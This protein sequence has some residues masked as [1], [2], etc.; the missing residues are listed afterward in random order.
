MNNSTPPNSNFPPNIDPNTF[1][2]LGAFIGAILASDLS[3]N[4]QNSVGNW[5][6][7]VGQYLLTSAAQQQLIQGR[8]AKN[9]S[10]KSM[11]G[12]DF[13]KNSNQSNCSQQDE[14]DYILQKIKLIEDE[15]RKL[16]KDSNS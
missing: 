13:F 7:L 11:Q 10:Q 12:N 5:F 15:L 9:N 1:A 6:E 8:I 2:F 16:K 4:E 3:I 14:I